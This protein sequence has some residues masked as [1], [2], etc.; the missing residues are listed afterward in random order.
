MKNSTKTRLAIL[1]TAL[2]AFAAG[3]GDDDDDGGGDGGQLSHEELITQADAIC[4]EGGNQINADAREFSKA[5][6]DDLDGLVHTII[7]P[8]YRDQIDQLRELQPPAEDK[9]QYDRFVNGFEDGVE[10]LDATPEDI[11]GGKAFTT[12]VEARGEAKDLGMVSCS[13]GADAG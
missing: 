1:L 13:R 4:T 2:A 11:N 5:N 9:A 12:F 3:C 8:G 10:Q 6:F 7:V